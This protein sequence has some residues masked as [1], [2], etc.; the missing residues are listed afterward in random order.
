MAAAD[1]GPVV[2]LE[3][4]AIEGQAEG[5]LVG[6]FWLLAVPV[7]RAHTDWAAAA[8]SDKGHPGSPCLDRLQVAVAAAAP[9]AAADKAVAVREE[10]VVV[11]VVQ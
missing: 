9:G 2:C 5:S 6:Q 7:H 1:S 4:Q 10:A 8:E 11:L 3:K